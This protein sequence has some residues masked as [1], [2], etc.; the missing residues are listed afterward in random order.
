MLISFIIPVY[1]RANILY[2]TMDSV[3]QSRW[4]DYEIILVNN[5]SKDNSGAICDA[6]AEKYPQIHVKHLSENQ[7]PGG[8]RNV[9]MQM[10]QGEWL[11]FLDSDDLICTENLEKIALQVNTMPSD[12]DL[13]VL[14]MIDEFDG[15]RWDFHFYN[16]NEILS[17]AEFVKNYPYRIN[18]QLWNYMFKRDSVKENQISFIENSIFD[19]VI[20]VYDMFFFT[21]KIACIKEYFYCYRRGIATNSVVT[22][23]QKKYPIQAY[24]Y[25]MNKIYQD[26]ILFKDTNNYVRK[27]AYIKL[28]EFCSLSILNV[29]PLSSKGYHKIENFDF[30]ES[31]GQCNIEEFVFQL[32]LKIREDFPYKKCYIAVGG[33]IT[34]HLIDYLAELECTVLGVIDNFATEIQTPQERKIP[35][36]KR[37][38]AANICG[39]IPILLTNYS[40]IGD[41][42]K[43]YLEEQ[44]LQVVEW[45]SD[46]LTEE[47]YTNG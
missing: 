44:G 30:F 24:L 45:H 7:G 19:D 13:I 21:N 46:L 38:E 29:R 20:F 25:Y 15:V 34:R 18:S 26:I 22:Q 12:V 28:M 31:F 41:K 23:G 32:F 1:N 42:V 17:Y 4:K 40:I 9:G 47:V 11:F 36:Y 2:E 27:N 8:A 5:G 33:K 10:A 43:K 16:K 3:L 35:V 14:D 39:D 6:Y 37:E